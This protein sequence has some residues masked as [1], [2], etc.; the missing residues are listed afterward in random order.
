M[1]KLFFLFVMSTWW[2]VTPPAAVLK[3]FKAKLPEASQVK[4]SK[5]NAHEYEADFK[6]NKRSYSANFN[7]KGTWLETESP[8]N[9]ISL[10]KAVQDAINTSKI[11][12]ATIKKLAKIEKASGKTT[13]ELDMK[14]GKKIIEK[15]YSGDGVE[16]K[17]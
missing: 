3:A 9:F 15:Y 7:E 2:T 6:L 4:W 12:K 1:L 5:E 16:I 14:K 11:N 13:Y 17:K 8:T 10:P